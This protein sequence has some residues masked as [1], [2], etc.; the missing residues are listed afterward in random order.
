MLHDVVL[1]WPHS[2]NI[3][4]PEHAHEFYFLFQS[5][6]PAI[7]LVATYCNK[8][9]K[10]VQHVVSKNVVICCVEMLRAFGQPLYNIIQQCC[11]LLR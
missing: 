9:A 5:I 11:D 6:A 7:Q 4:A 2:C 8:V 1:V 10:R 3:V